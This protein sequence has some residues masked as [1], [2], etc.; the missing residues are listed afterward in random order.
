MEDVTVCKGATRCVWLLGK[1]AVK[2]P[3]FV[4]WRNFL[5]GLLANNQERTFYRELKDKRLAKVYYADP[6]G[7]CLVME[8]ADEVKKILGR[9]EKRFLWVCA[10]R[11]LPVECKPSSI[12]VFGGKLKLIDYGN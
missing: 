12:G 4:G 10:A 5:Q 11:G 3:R 1:F 6:L 8:R 7:V 2:F 9:D